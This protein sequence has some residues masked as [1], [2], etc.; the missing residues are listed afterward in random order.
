METI[1]EFTKADID[2]KDKKLADFKGKTLLIVN[3]ASKCGLTPQY[4]GLEALYRKYKDRGLVV[5]GFPAND[6]AGQEPGTN[7]E[8]KTFCTTKFNV[9]FPMMSK[10][11]VVG[12]SMDPLYAW[13]L[14]RTDNKPIEWNFAKF[15][16]GADGKT[17]TRF[18]SR[19]SPQD[20]ALVAAI[21]SAL[22]G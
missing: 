8:I 7:E 19:T 14:A 20:P 3:T 15:L 17:V 16:V 5:I 21:E 6:F 18:G 4:E 9:S 1:Y 22:G 10:I 12:E 13:L 2:G 11:T